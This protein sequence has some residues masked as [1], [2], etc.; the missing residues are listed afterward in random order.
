MEKLW[1]RSTSGIMVHQRHKCAKFQSRSHL[2][3]IMLRNVCIS[4]L[5]QV[6]N[7]GKR[8]LA[9]KNYSPPPL[10]YRRHF[11]GYRHI[12]DVGQFTGTN[13]EV[14][15]VMPL[16]ELETWLATREVYKIEVKFERLP[17]HYRCCPVHWY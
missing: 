15:E 5:K 6:M 16:W 17:P 12:C 3:Q 9:W 11:S 1:K 10:R 7:S 14:M 4:V 2:W 13:I 8:C